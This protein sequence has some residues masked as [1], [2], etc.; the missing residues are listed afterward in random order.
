MVELVVALAVIAVG[1]I[2]IGTL[3]RESGIVTRRGSERDVAVE[4]MHKK[5]EAI[6]DLDYYS[7]CSETFPVP[8]LK[9]AVGTVTVTNV[10]PDSGWL[11]LVIVQVSWRKWNSDM[12]M[13]DSLVTYVTRGGINP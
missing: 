10:D 7:I 9:D 3:M 11:K 2:G 1:I 12:I 6:R 4:I 8:E 5:M 13:S